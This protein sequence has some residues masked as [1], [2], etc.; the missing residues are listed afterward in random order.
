MRRRIEEGERKR[1]RQKICENSEEKH[2]KIKYNI[3]YE[4]LKI[5]KNSNI[6]I[7]QSRNEVLYNV[8]FQHLSRLRIMI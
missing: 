1:A 5:I 6:N 4:N 8:S 2:R 3:K 7:N